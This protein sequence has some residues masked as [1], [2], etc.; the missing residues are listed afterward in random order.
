MNNMTDTTYKL[1]QT[2]MHETFE[3]QPSRFRIS[4][5]D[6]IFTTASRQLK[7]FPFKWYIPIGVLFTFICWYF[8]KITNVGLLTRLAS[9][10]QY[11]F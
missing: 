10:L 6:T 4:L 11:G 2:K 8:S 9:I 1:L 7:T 3:L 5:L